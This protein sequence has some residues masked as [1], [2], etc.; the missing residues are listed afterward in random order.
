MGEEFH[1]IIKLVSGEEIFS[2]VTVDEDSDDPI[3]VLQNPVIFK[4][5]NNGQGNFIK[6]KP[7]MELT[8]E[9][10]FFIRL[11]KVITLTESKDEKLLSVYNHYIS[12]TNNSHSN[13]HHNFDGSVR[14]N[15]SMGYI[16]T[17]DDARKKL[18][19]LLKINKSKEV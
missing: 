1:A 17:V 4:I 8:E 12:D 14:P 5:I 19:E 2:F 9:D 15:K 18:E 16:S 3:L 13:Y 7:W 10:I 6:V 11:S